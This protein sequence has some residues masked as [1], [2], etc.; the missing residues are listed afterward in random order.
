MGPSCRPGGTFP[1][2]LLHCA[3]GPRWVS[4]RFTHSVSPRDGHGA[5]GQLSALL[6]VLPLQLPF[7]PGVHQAEEQDEEGRCKQAGDVQFG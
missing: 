1:R 3:T 5:P 2:A 7:R 4:L 6:L